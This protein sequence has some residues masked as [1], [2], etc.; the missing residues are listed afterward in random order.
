MKEYLIKLPKD[1]KNIGISLDNNIFGDTNDSQNWGEFSIPLPTPPKGY[2]WL[3]TTSDKDGY[4]KIVARKT[5][6]NP[7]SS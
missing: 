2:N 5:W 3:F 1:Y 6:I 4:Y 7:Q